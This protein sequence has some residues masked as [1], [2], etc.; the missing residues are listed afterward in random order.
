MLNFHM[1]QLEYHFSKY[2][3]NI[4]DALSLSKFSF[5]S[6]FCLSSKYLTIFEILDVKRSSI[7]S[8]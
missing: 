4:K 5:P 3:C 6:D 7:R 8:I 1:L 2:D